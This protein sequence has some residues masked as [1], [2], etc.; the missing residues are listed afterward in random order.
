MSLKETKENFIC[1]KCKNSWIKD[2]VYL[3]CDF[4]GLMNYEDVENMK[5]CKNY[6]SEN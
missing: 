2:F 3:I 5:S 1:T 6:E 4:N